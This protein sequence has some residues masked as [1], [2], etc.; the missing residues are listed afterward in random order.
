MVDR[1]RRYLERL[2]RRWK[3]GLLPYAILTALEE[4]PTYGYALL[5]RL[6]AW[7]A[8][9]SALGPSLVYPALARLRTAGLIVSFHGTESRGPVRKYY[10]LTPV[11]LELL[12]EIRAM[13]VLLSR[14]ALPARAPK[15]PPAGRPWRSPSAG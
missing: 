1:A 9:D 15:E 4:G 14:G 2:E 12:P 10:Q 6:K 5:E 11:G 13:A 7:G 8:V 3:D